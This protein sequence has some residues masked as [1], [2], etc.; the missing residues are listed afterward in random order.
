MSYSRVSGFQLVEEL[1]H[2]HGVEPHSRGS[3]SKDGGKL[4]VELIA[5][6]SAVVDPVLNQQMI[7]DL[8]WPGGGRRAQPLNIKGPREVL[9]VQQR[10][11]LRRLCLQEHAGQL[12]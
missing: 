6:R 2:Q 7:R 1:L 5:G 8:Y 3:L 10:A 12:R 11:G 9:Q 4:R